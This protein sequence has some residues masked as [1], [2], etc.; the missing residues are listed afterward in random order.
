MVPLLLAVLLQAPQAP[1]VDVPVSLE[2]VREGLQRPGRFDLPPEPPR[3]WRRPLFRVTVEEH[4]LFEMGAWED[5]SIVPPWVR[6]QRPLYH[7]EFLSMVTP[8]EVRGPTLHPCCNAMPLVQKLG[9]LI[10]GGMRAAQKARARREV[11]RVMRDAG[12]KMK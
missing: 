10:T 8:E 4:L 5:T 6:P 2:R 11:E 12:I 1:P 7:Y 3:P 9:G